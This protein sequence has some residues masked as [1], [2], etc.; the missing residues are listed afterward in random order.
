MYD[1]DGLLQQN[2]FVERLRC[3][4]DGSNPPPVLRD[5]KIKLT[6]RCNL[7]CRMCKYW[8]K[9]REPDLSTIQWQE[10]L[11][12]LVDL[13]CRKVHFSGGEVF[14]RPDFL[15][16]VERATSLGLK[17]NLT[18]N[19]TLVDKAKARRL[20]KAGVN[21]LSLSLDGPRAKVHDEIRGHPGAFKKALRTLRWLRHYSAGAKRP[22]KLRIN[23]VIMRD[24]FRWLPEM[25]NLAGD[26]GAVDLHPMPVDEKG[27]SRKRLSRSQIELYNREV[28]PR[29][30]ALRQEWGLPTTPDKIYP[31]GVTPRDIGYS[32][33]GLYA[34]GFYERHLCLAPWLHHFIAWNGVHLVAFQTQ[35]SFTNR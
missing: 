2:G 22:I 32:K 13:G 33:Q 14:M 23:F 7:R 20:V 25:V 21:S 27:E 29:V 19:G 10:T 9:K 31:F 6:S 24:N 15:D 4:L 17:T 16:I 30:L 5:A 3:S 28:A 1:I 34:R 26:L 11:A 8:R 35:P 18:T 12:Q